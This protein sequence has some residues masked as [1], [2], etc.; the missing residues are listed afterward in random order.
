MTE[1]PLRF[2]PFTLDRAQR[3]LLKDGAL[4]EL[5]PRYFDALV[6][7]AAAPGELVTKDRFMAE[8]WAGI[9]VTDE[10]LTQCIRT[11]RRALGDDA[12]APRF[13]Q[14]VPKYGY[15]FV[16]GEPAAT[17]PTLI[18]PTLQPIVVGGTLGGALAG[19]IGGLL[20]GLIATAITPANIGGASLLLVLFG[21]AVTIAALGAAGVSL[22]MALAQRRVSSG[23]AALSLG[24]AAGGLTIGALTELIG[25]DAFTLLIG[26]APAHMTGAGE[27]VLI[28][29]AV[30][31]ALWQSPRARPGLRTAL[32]ALIGALAGLLVTLMGGRMLA[33]SL[34]SLAGSRL[35]LDRIGAMLGESGFGPIS[36]ALSA[37]LEGALFTAAIVW[38]IRRF[39]AAAR[40]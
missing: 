15:R 4:V 32:S 14:T 5:N 9:P 40:P 23:G 37:M 13:I 6:V 19:G 38:T 3:R 20:Y 21:I 33:G 34:D 39:S 16:A 36:Q 7:L 18:A 17:V 25:T 11:L 22:G 26:S 10:A 28:G 24:G 1:T 27:G 35:N 31:L 8:V 30:G 2:G 12:A 29:G